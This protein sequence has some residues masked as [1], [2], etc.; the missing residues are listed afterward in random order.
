MFKATVTIAVTKT[1]YSMPY[2]RIETLT[3]YGDTEDEAA[4][5]AYNLG[6]NRFDV[7]KVE[8]ERVD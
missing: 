3:F 7:T 4:S 1:Y 6:W 8:I 2:Y 5:K